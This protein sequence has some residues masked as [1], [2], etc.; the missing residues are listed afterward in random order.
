MQAMSKALA[1]CDG[2]ELYNITMGNSRD[3]VQQDCG[4]IRQWLT[5]KIRLKDGLPSTQVIDGILRIINEV[6]P[7]LIH[8]WG[9]E[10]FWGLLSARGYIT[11]PV[12]LE[13]Q[14]LRYTCAEAYMGGLTP[15][16]IKSCIRPRDW[17][18][19][20]RRI[21]KIQDVHRR[22]GEYEKEMLAA[23][24]YIST[25]SQWVRASIAPYC[26]NQAHIFDTLMAVRE[27][28]MNATPWDKTFD[29]DN[30]QLLSVATGAIPYKG[31]HVAL[32][33]LAIL[34]KHYPNIT[35]KVVGNYQQ[36]RKEFHKHG[37]VKFLERQ[38]A[39]LDITRNVVFT[40]ALDTPRLLQEM[41]Q[42]HIMLHTS[43]VETYSLAL[44]EAMAVGLPGVISYAGAMPELAQDGVTGLF[45]S[46]CDHRQ[47]AHQVRRLIQEPNLARNISTASRHLAMQR[48]NI[49]TVTTRQIEIY[50]QV[51]SEEKERK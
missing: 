45:Y 38:I 51:L 32:R 41:Q 34:K 50:K 15:Q 25:Q 23:H 19:P 22:W 16:E 21:D 29:N 13:I 37:Y 24:R 47:C 46:P 31:L 39:R 20:R 11:R 40:G 12:L 42:S 3:F 35:L 2:I 33:A 4:K 26:S 18:V 36:T 28:F 27:D 14:G 44:A 48:N 10:T 9:M 8:I 7:D 17:F 1:Q 5:P 49:H 43:H 30:I 6:N